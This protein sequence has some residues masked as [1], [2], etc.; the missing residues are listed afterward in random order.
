MR[1][2][3]RRIRG[4]SLNEVM[5]TTAVITVVAAVATPKFAEASQRARE[6]ALKY[7][8][9]TLRKAVDQ[10]NADTGGWPN[11]ISDL[12]GTEAPQYLWL[13]GNVEE[14]GKRHYNGPYLGYGEKG[15]RFIPKDPVSSLP[16]KEYHSEGGR[17]RIFS[18]AKGKDLSGEEFSKY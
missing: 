13:K 4:V 14:W 1:G 2:C 11:N 3:W 9:Q 7:E 17:L 18:S 16:F 6:A 8:L 12:I 10:F 15:S 5:M